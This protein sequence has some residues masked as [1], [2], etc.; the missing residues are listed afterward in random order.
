M[1]SPSRV[2]LALVSTE[3]SP[4]FVLDVAVAEDEA[5]AV[6]LADALDPVSAELRASVDIVGVPSG[7]AMGR[8][9]APVEPDTATSKVTSGMN[10][11]PDILNLLD[12]A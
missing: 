3:Q 9:A 10:S 2:T 12:P 1:V 4:P 5:R 8:S 11:L 7:A 6:V